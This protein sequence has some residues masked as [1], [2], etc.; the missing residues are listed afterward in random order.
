MRIGDL[1]LKF[2][3]EQYLKRQNLEVGSEVDL[4]G[5]KLKIAGMRVENAN[6]WTLRR[7]G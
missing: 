5:V 4:P 6:V 1:V 2:L 7:Y 3:F